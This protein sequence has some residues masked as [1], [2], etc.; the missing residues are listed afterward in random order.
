MDIYIIDSIVNN[1]LNSKKNIRTQ[2]SSLHKLFKTSFLNIDEQ[3]IK[4]RIMQIKEYKEIL[5]KLKT[6]PVIEQRSQEWY[7]IRKSLITA[8]DFAQALG[9][10]KFGSKTQF[11]RNK[12][13]Y[14]SNAIDMS[15]PALQ[16][17]VKYEEV[18]KKFY[19]TKMNIHVHE[20]GLIR[21]PTIPFVGASP[22]G[23]SENGIMLEIKCPWRRK[24]TGAIPEQYYYQIQ[25][26][27]EVCDLE[28]CDYLECYITE[29]DNY[30][31]MMQDVEAEYR[32]VVVEYVNN[33]YIYG[34]INDLT[35]S[36]SYAVKVYYYKITDY[37]LKRVNRDKKF[38]EEILPCIEEVWSNVLAYREDKELYNKNVKPKKEKMPP[39]PLFIN[40]ED[41]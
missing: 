18:A 27:L 29:Y 10:G 15:I 22:D 24:N 31:D 23:I 37:L 16:W 5:T 2:L 25:G 40:V 8:S 11:L 3:C 12:C 1:V 38:F 9:K 33:E 21:H 39:K 7:D 35:F 20:F 26:Q 28:D 4:R 41:D 32:G 17:G 19:E 36:R 14:E 30:D 13:G 34:D 6:Y